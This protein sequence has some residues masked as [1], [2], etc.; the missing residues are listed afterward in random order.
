ME[1]VVSWFFKYRVSPDQCCGDRFG[2]KGNHQLQDLTDGRNGVSIQLN[3]EGKIHGCRR[4]L[5]P[6]KIDKPSRSSSDI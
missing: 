6:D 1:S 4:I 3:S 2:I 5:L